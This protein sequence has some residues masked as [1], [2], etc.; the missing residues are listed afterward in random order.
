MKN[1]KPALFCLTIAFGS[2]A[3]AV[4]KYAAFQIAQ[5]PSKPAK[6]LPARVAPEGQ[7]FKTFALLH[8]GKRIAK[9]TVLL[10]EGT[11]RLPFNLRDQL[12]PTGVFSH[13][14]HKKLLATALNGFRDIQQGIRGAAGSTIHVQQTLSRTKK[15]GVGL[16]A[17]DAS[18]N[19]VSNIEFVV[20]DQTQCDADAA[21]RTPASY[22]A[23]PSTPSLKGRNP[24][25][26]QSAYGAVWVA[27][28]S[29]LSRT[30][31]STNLTGK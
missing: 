26:T 12:K 23:A 7:A 28:A 6:C 25:A 19:R 31:S 24:A 9:A 4:S 8:N 11:S 3:G 2:T 10:A 15:I 29:N 27:D 13:F 21:A 20:L 17:A 5:E 16:T 14:S 22:Q 18:G 1:L 30:R